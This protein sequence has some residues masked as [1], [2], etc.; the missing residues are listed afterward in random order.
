MVMTMVQVWGMRVGVAVPGMNM[1][2]GVGNAFEDI[3]LFVR[4]C[5]VGLRMSMTVFVLVQ[6]MNVSMR[7]QF[8]EHQH[9]PEYHQRQRYKEKSSG[10]FS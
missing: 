7:M 2:V 10:L 8:T 9:H 5:M 3:F 1:P 4:M 6:F